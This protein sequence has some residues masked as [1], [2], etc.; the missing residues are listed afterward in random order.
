MIIQRLRATHIGHLRWNDRINLLAIVVGVLAGFFIITGSLA[1]LFV[2]PLLAALGLDGVLRSHPAARFRGVTVTT[3]QILGPVAFTVA[4][5]LFFRY[6]A[7]GY[8]SLL[9]SVGTGLAFGAASYAAYFSLDSESRA[10]GLSRTILLTAAYAGLF[11]FLAAFYSF[12]LAL[13]VAAALAG[14]AGTIAS[15]E[16]YRDAGL[17]SADLVI[18]SLGSGFVIAQVRWAAGF[19]RI[20]GL[21]AAMLLM[22]VFYVVTG[23]TLS[24]V[25]RKLDRRTG[26]EFVAVGLAGLAIV[27]A[28]RLI[29]AG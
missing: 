27:I 7:S 29:T 9:A 23:L 1:A 17:N 20:D 28:G 13:P 14:L 21:L 26:T 12:D 22:L 11:G 25:T 8:W 4:A 15:V 18:Y 16:I 19:V 6:I 3:I 24:A 5:A 10:G 2:L